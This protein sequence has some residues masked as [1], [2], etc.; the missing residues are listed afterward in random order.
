MAT[1]SVFPCADFRATYTLNRT[2]DKDNDIAVDTASANRNGKGLVQQEHVADFNRI[3][4][5]LH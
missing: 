1:P 4:V 2:T 3:G 5:S